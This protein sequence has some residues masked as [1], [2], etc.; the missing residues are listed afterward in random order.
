MNTFLQGC[1]IG[2]SIAAPVGPIGILTI[3]RSLNEGR[4]AGFVTGLGAATADGVYGLV[5][6]LGLSALMIVLQSIALW[7]K[8]AGGS[9]LIYLGYRIFISRPPSSKDPIASN[10]NW[11]NFYTTFFL[12]IT[13]PATIFVFLSVFT[14]LGLA[15]GVGDSIQIGGLVAGVF[16]GSALWW[17]FLSYGISKLSSRIG[18]DGLVW[19]NR[20]SGSLVIGFGLFAYISA[21]LF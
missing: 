8:I 9:F 20:I 14:S 2:F 3:Q 16:L 17:F 21:I 19:I 11:Y 4:K 6:G 15:N 10:G 1:I 18:T 5:A 13:S 12:T 7:L